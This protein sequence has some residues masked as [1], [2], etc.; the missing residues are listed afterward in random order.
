MKTIKH[1]SYTYLG[2][3]YKA[4]TTLYMLDIQFDNRQTESIFGYSKDGEDV[5][6]RCLPDMMDY[7]ARG[8]STKRAYLDEVEVDNFLEGGHVIYG[9]VQEQFLDDFS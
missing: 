6:F 7:Y 2:H 8:K 9:D 1:V 3:G 5:L 4:D